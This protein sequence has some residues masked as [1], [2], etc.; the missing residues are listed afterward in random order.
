MLVA[1]TVRAVRRGA[2]L[3][4]IGRLVPEV[5]RLLGR[6][7]IDRAIPLRVRGRIFIAVAYNVQPI[8]LI[9]DFVP[10]IGL[11]D[12]ALVILWAVRGTVRGA[13]HEA[14]V[15]HWTGTPAGLAMLLRFAGCGER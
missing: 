1:A 11:A 7:S 14:I 9:P 12:N 13:G 5:A 15:R 10:I 4:D 6:L 8:N 2:N 3:A